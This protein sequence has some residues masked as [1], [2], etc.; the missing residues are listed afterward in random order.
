MLGNPPWVKVEWEEGG[1]LGD[2]NPLFVLRRH[3]TAQIGSLRVAAFE[4]F[5]GLQS[6]WLTEFEEAEATQTYINAP[7]NY[8]LL[9]GQKANLYKCFL[10]QAW[11]VG[12]EGRI[13]AFQH[14]EGVYDDP[15]GGLFRVDR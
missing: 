3:S 7:Q 1:L 2:Y 14:P 9:Q 6:A 8:P 12:S 10:P 5:D 11:M 15:K 4:R 13:A